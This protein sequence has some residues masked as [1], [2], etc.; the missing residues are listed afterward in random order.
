MAAWPHVGVDAIAMAGA[1][2]NEVPKIISREMPFKDGAIMT[3]AGGE[4]TNIIW[5]IRTSSAERRTLLVQ[6]VREIAAC[7]RMVVLPAMK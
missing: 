5:T 1:F 6:R 3:I 2:I 4:A 7:L